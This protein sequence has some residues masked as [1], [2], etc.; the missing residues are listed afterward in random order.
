[1]RNREKTAILIFVL[2]LVLGCSDRS[3]TGVKSQTVIRVDHLA[4]TL[5]EFNEFFEPLKMSYAK[6]Q[7]DNDSGLGE[8]RLRFLLQLLE[9]MII[10]R[11]AEELDLH[12]SSRELEEA[13]GNIEG[14]YCEDSFKAIF[15]KQAISLETWKERFRRQLLV[16]KVINKDL[17]EEISVNPAEIRDYYDKHNE[18]WTHG[19]QI[20]V[21]HILLPKKEEANLVLTRLRKGEDFATLARLY[22]TAPESERGGDMGYVI[23]GHLPKCLEDPIFALE[24]DKVSPVIKTPYGYHI[25][26]SVEKRKPG[27]LK[28]DDWI[29]EIRGR[30]R[31]EKLEIAYGPWLATLRSRYKITVNKE[32]I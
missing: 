4:M 23:R 32:I 2:L 24:K 31:K 7:N 10:L 29:E 16:E 14:D 20:R 12:I 3:E 19:E 17:F 26:K 30:A 1:M 28:M 18:E 15:L 9:E 13:M 25:F 5:T 22:S 21:L 8:A 6:E 11:R 27:K